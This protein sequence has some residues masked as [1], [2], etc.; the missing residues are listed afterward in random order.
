MSL[1]IVGS[2]TSSC[3]TS[4]PVRTRPCSLTTRRICSLRS[5]AKVSRTRAPPLAELAIPHSS[6]RAGK[7]VLMEKPLAASS[8]EAEELVAL[9]RG[10]D[11]RRPDR[12]R[13]GRPRRHLDDARRDRRGRAVGALRHEAMSAEMAERFAGGV[14]TLPARTPTGRSHCSSWRT[15]IIR[16]SR[17]STCS[18][19]A[20]GRKVRARARHGPDGPGTGAR[21]RRGPPL[22]SGDVEPAKPNAVR[23]A[24][25]P[26]DRRHH[27]AER[28]PVLADG[29]ASAVART[30]IQLDGCGGGRPAGSCRTMATPS[31]PRPFPATTKPARL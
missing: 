28:P 12:G 10:R 22:L 5:T 31:G 13:A 19:S 23:A 11:L 4:S 8:A 30:S 1:R 17:T 24:R 7:H 16:T 29:A 6:L 26:G 2:L 9:A 14:A 25:V 27:A 21:R 18:S 20:C 3:C 15:N